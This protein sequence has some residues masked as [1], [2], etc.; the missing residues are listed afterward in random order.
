MEYQ[1]AGTLINRY[2]SALGAAAFFLA[3]AGRA[4][5]LLPKEP[6]KILPFFVF[7]SPLPMM[8]CFV[9]LQK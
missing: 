9:W 6:L 1:P 4:G 5:R 8:F 3:A 7:L 2:L